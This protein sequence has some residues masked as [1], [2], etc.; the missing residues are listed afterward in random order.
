MRDPRVGSPRRVGALMSDEPW[1]TRREHGQAEEDGA[2]ASCDLII[3]P[4]GRIRE[5]VEYDA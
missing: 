1:T 3:D 2:G 5:I 4:Q